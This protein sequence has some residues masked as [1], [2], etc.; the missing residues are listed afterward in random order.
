MA[1]SGRADIVMSSG[2]VKHHVDAS[3]DNQSL[4]L[5]HRMCSESTTYSQIY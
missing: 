4:A 5:T 3:L 2:E 1:G